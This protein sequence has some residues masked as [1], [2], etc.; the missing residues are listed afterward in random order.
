VILL[1]ERGIQVRDF[2]TASAHLTTRNLMVR[3]H[4][5]GIPKTKKPTGLMA[6]HGNN[7]ALLDLFPLIKGLKIGSRFNLFKIM[8]LQSWGSTNSHHPSIISRVSY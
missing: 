4:M 7:R 1:S 5:R 6:L 3:Y 2:P 8:N